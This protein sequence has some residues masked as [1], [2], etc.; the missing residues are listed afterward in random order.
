MQM[1]QKK[2]KRPVT[3]IEIMIVIL[4]IGMIGGAL[5]F[6]MR[7]SLDKGKVFK[8]EQNANRVYD[9]V[10]M[11]YATGE[12]KFEDC[13]KKESVIEVLNKS[14][15]VNDANK[16]FTDGWGEDLQLATKD[17]GTDLHVFSIKAEQWHQK[18][19]QK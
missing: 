7:G 17:Q 4:L 8:S 11:A 16:L 15:L 19:L 1:K 10:M 18:Q 9:I 12:I 13:T 5:A 6:N 14:P 2:K 3:L